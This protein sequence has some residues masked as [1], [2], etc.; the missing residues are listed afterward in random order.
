MFDA[1]L[2]CGYFPHELPPPFQTTSLGKAITPQIS[3]LSHPFIYDPKFNKPVSK[4]SRFNLARA[5]TLRRILSIPNPINYVQLA[6]IISSDWQQIIQHIHQ[7]TLSLSKPIQKSGNLRAVQRFK[8]FNE[9][10]EIRAIE[11]TNCRYL[12]T[13]DINAFYPSIYTHSIPWAFHTKDS[14][15]SQRRYNQLLGN[16]LDTLIRNAQDQQTK[17]IPIGTDTSLIIAESILTVVDQKLKNKF[18]SIRGFRY[19]D[20]YELCFW[21]FAE[22]EAALFILQ[23]L[24]TE[25]ELQLNPSKTRIVELPQRIERQWVTE[26]RI[27]EFR[28]GTQAQ[29]TDIIQYFDQA[30]DLW[31][32]H[33]E[34]AVLKYAVSRTQS[35]TIPR[36]N[37]SLYEAL[38]LKC[39]LAE[40][41][42]LP[43]VIEQLKRYLEGGYQLNQ[44]LICET[45]A[46]I[47]ELHAPRGHGSEVA[48]VIW[49]SLILKLPISEKTANIIVTMDDSVVALLAL[50]A[51]SKGIISTTVDFN[52]WSQYMTSDELYGCNWLLCYQAFKNN[53]LPSKDGKNYLIEDPEF[54]FLS[55]HNVQFYDSMSSVVYSV[56][57]VPRFSAPVFPTG[58]Y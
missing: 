30:F 57:P 18:P 39:S 38:L 24:L 5:G 28:E 40:A 3:S 2:R 36:K 4:L 8:G 12:L 9:L 29:H 31:A 33:H 47:V 16:K 49:G 26:L 21:S 46:R 48:W 55:S 56:P 27:F 7:S 20:D 23:E 19:V 44:D 50:D 14:A 52:L 53:W 45:F 15:K 37:W 11:R 25:F 10:P 34:E 43:I 42:T 13:A 54:S 41:G 32:D 58:G 35:I 51:K 6:H 1:L 17:G 22:A